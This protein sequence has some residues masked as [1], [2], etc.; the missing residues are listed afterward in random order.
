MTRGYQFMM[1][2]YTYI[3]NIQT[4]C[5]PSC[6]GQHCPFPPPSR[7]KSFRGHHGGWCPLD[8][9]YHGRKDRWISSSFMMFHEK[10][11]NHNGRSSTSN[12]IQHETTSA[13]GLEDVFICFLLLLLWL[14]WLWLWLW[15]WF[16][17]LLLLLLWCL[18][19]WCLV[20]GVCCLLFVVCCWLLVVGCWLLVFG[21][22]CLVFGVVVVCS[23]FGGRC[24]IQQPQLD[25]GIK[26]NI[27]W[28]EIP[29]HQ[30][31]TQPVYL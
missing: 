1:S 18:V 19:L 14:W 15:L 26:I 22:W 8:L 20:F 23:H 17:L 13:W 28:M 29:N 2:L 11:R 21:V 31:F 10:C 16:L 7:R 3:L 30:R 5:G 6:I 4:G 12:I 9:G 24:S 27:V 25:L